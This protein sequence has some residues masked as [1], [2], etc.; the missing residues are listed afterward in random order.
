MDDLG[1]II[2]TIELLI[3]LRN[4]TWNGLSNVEQ[5]GVN[6]YVYNH[7]FSLK[8]NKIRTTENTIKPSAQT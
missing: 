2:D 7:F 4:A 1:S 6:K 8:I 5:R 3:D